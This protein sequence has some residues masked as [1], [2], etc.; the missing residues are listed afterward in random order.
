MDLSLTEHFRFMR[1][2][3]LIVNLYGVLFWKLS[4][5]P[6][7][8]KPFLTFSSIRFGVSGFMLRCLIHLD[9]SF[10]QGDNYEYICTLLHVDIQL[11]QD[12]LLKMLSSP[13]YCFGFFVKNQVSVRLWI[14]VLV[15]H[16]IPL[17]NMSA[18][19][20]IPWCFYYYSSVVGLEI[21]NG[22]ASGSSF[23]VQD[24]F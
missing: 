15:S 10:V 21:R 18:F 19:M 8:S 1:S 22:D 16:L 12:H 6:V 4:I 14:Y 2:H 24:C 9:L 13:L 7:S 20:L 23:I 17:I 5:V 11:S 3:L